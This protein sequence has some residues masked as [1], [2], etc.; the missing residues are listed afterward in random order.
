MKM[1]KKTII[2]LIVVAVAAY[3]IWNKRKAGKTVTVSDA[4]T[5]AIPGSL[6][7]ILANVPFTN[8]EV[9]KINATMARV[10]ASTI[11]REEMQ[12]KASRNGNT[13]DEQVVI[14]AIWLLYHPN[15]DPNAAWIAGPDGK[16]DY[17]WRLQ[18]KVLNLN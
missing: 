18:Q 4:G 14:D 5:G 13:F 9:R 7:Y 12:A 6:E 3:L 10:N 11:A 1:N 16:T 17:G 8:K 15:Q 2:I